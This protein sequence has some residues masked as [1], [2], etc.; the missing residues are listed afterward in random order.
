MRPATY[1]GPVT[2]ATVLLTDDAGHP[3]GSVA[4]TLVEANVF[5]NVRPALGPLSS[6]S[7]AYSR[8]LIVEQASA[9]LQGNLIEHV[10]EAWRHWDY[11]LVKARESRSVTEETRIP[12]VSHRTECIQAF[13]IDILLDRIAVATTDL[14]V[15]ATFTIDIADAIFREGRLVGL[16]AGGCDLGVKLDV[17][18]RVLKPV[19]VPVKLAPFRLERHRQIEL[20]MRLQFGAGI[21][22]LPAPRSLS[23]PADDWRGG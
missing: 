21:P 13:S 10:I 15:A 5:V 8:D 4:G 19:S 20:P 14:T 6:A 16:G 2:A 7:W 17:S 23:R 12:L 18:A 1:L 22:I 9:I 3:T 11:L